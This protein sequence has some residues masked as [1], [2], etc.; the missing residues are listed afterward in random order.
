VTS[1]I[2]FLDPAVAEYAAAHSTPP[3]P[4]QQALIAE[5]AA[6]GAHSRMQIG[7]LQGAFMSVI[8][9]AIQPKLAVEVGTFTGY[10]A[11]A[12]ARAMP[13]DGR[14]ICCDR[15]RQ[16]TDIGRSAWEE[17]GVMDRIEVRIGPAL[18][19]LRSLPREQSIDLAFI[20]AEKTEYIDF[21]EELVGRLAPHGLILADNVLWDGHVVD[22]RDQSASTSAIRRFNEYVRDDD[23][24]EVALLPVGD[25]VSVISR[26]VG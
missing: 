7:A 8:T 25:G 1:E 21:F 23:R 22:D 15:S 13:V 14:L 2:A 19:T 10:S 18:E 3:D 17:A 4:V 26:R 5:T 9:M 20:D 24:V 11:L 6:L 12:V 16:W